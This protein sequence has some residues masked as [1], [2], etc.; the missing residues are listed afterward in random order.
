MSRN[1]CLGAIAA[2]LI[3]WASPKGALSA[4]ATSGLILGGSLNAPI[5]IEVF[6]DFECPGCRSLYRDLMRP[7]LQ[8]YASKD[9]VC[10][11]YREFPLDKHRYSWKAARY[12]E[13][14][15]RLGQ[16]QGL[17]VFDALF[18]QQAEWAQDG[19]I[20]AVI[21]KA[22]SSRE[23]TKLKTVLRAPGIDQPIDCGV[24]LGKERGL[25]GTP[26]MFVYYLGKSQKV[27][28]PQMMSYENLKRFFD[29]ILK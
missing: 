4:D 24:K 27:E 21:A 2:M 25:R 17:R 19:N 1:A 8:D 14:A 6:S 7:V 12:C 10:V 20:E 13:A 11:I 22:I 9:K 29:Q 5:R 3:L 28:S 23:L 15:F 26:T 18:A 16:E